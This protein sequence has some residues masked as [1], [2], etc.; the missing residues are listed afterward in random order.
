[1][2]HHGPISKSVRISSLS[3]QA[4]SGYPHYSLGR[5][6]SPSAPSFSLRTHSR[7]VGHHGPISKNVRISSLAFG[8]ARC[9]AHEHALRSSVQAGIT[10]LPNVMFSLA[11]KQRWIPAFAGMT[12]RGERESILV[13]IGAADTP[14]CPVFLATYPQQSCGAPR[15]HGPISKNVRISSL[16]FGPARCFASAGTSK[17]STGRDH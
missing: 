10:D 16:S 15:H 1:M 11:R 13:L 9:Y 6:T 7:A 14:V 8:P 17:L 2:G 5:Q 3:L 12:K 4:P